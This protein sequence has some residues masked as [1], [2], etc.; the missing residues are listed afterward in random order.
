MGKINVIHADDHDILRYG[1]RRYLTE[2]EDIELVGE[3]SNGK[4]CIQLFKQLRPH[5]CMI[6]IEMPD[7]NGI[8]AAQAIR[9]MEPDA[10]LLI[11][12][13]H[14]DKGTIDKAKMAGANGYLLK[15]SPKGEIIA[16][17]RQLVNGETLFPATHSK[18]SNTLEK[19]AQNALDENI[20]DREME[21][22]QLVVEGKSSPQIAK[23]LYISRRTVDTHRNNLM[24]KL[25]LHNTASLVRFALEHNL[26]Q[27]SV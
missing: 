24:K 17:I 25:D 13:M 22:L 6:D 18:L 7:V 8:E 2:H 21:I 9:K 16:A 5:V 11:L 10:K 4:E 15:S 19:T 26:V 23:K 27:T 12:T 20:T 3:A 1:I 14:S